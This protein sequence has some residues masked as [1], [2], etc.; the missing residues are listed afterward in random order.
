[1]SF[2]S[3]MTELA[4]ACRKRFA[5]TS[6]L[7]LDDMIKL[8]TPPAFPPGTEILGET[9]LSI[10]LLD[11]NRDVPLTLK[12]V[13]PAMDKPIKLSITFSSDNW[14][15]VSNAEL[16]F[17]KSDGT[18]LALAIP[19]ISSAYNPGTH[20]VKTANVTIPANTSIANNRAILRLSTDSDI[21]IGK[22]EKIIAT[23]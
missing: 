4:D 16:I 17:N 7:S 22:I 3:T 21:D 13:P 12:A 8:I 9:N 10:V 5:V 23:Y 6:K 2:S 1:M 19:E 20:W 15:S 18:Q 11:E 14:L